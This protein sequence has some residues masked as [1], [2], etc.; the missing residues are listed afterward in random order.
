M[1]TEDRGVEADSEVFRQIGCHAVTLPVGQQTGHLTD[2]NAPNGSMREGHLSSA[3]LMVKDASETLA[4]EYLV[5]H[6]IPA[7][8]GLVS[9]DGSLHRLKPLSVERLVLSRSV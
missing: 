6:L 4:V 3:K 9:Q 5:L 2:S 1:K 8:K 7:P